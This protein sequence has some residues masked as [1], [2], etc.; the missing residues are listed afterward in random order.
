MDNTN[1]QPTQEIKKKKKWLLP[2]ILG[3]VALV[4]IGAGIAGLFYFKSVALPK[5]ELRKQLDLADKYLS[6]MDYDNAILSYKAA[7]EIDPECE[8]AYLG[9]S[10]AYE[11]AISACMEEG[12]LDKAEKYLEKAVRDLK[13]GLNISESS[14]I[15]TKIQAFQEQKEELSSAGT[16]NLSKANIGDIVTF[17][18]YEQDNNTSNGAEPIEWKVLDKTDNRVLLISEYVLDC[19]PYNTVAENVT[20]ETCSLRRWLSDSFLYTAFSAEEQQKIPLVTLANPANSLH[21]T[22]GGNDTQDRVF[23][24]SFNEIRQYI[25]FTLWDEQRHYGFSE[26]LQV[27]PTAY[28]ISRGSFDYEFKESDYE[29]YLKNGGCS[30]NIIGKHSTCWWFRTPGKTNESAIAFDLDD[31]VSERWGYGICSENV[32]VRPAIYV[33]Y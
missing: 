7:I 18:T 10:D 1:M 32:G 6:D 11:E 21:G 26:E 9:L 3:V 29:G 16:M 8:E 28:A 4:V 31:E 22:Y 27:A 23:I 14:Q 15:K 19:Q 13:P 30:R 25:P 5:K 2:V 33:E 12:D 20:W 17:G 24:L